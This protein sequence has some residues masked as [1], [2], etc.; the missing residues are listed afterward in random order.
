M[1]PGNWKV[2]VR[3]EPWNPLGITLYMVSTDPNGRRSFVTNFTMQ[4]ITDEVH[5][6]V[7]RIEG[8]ADEVFSLLQAFMDAAWDAGVRPKSY[9][10]PQNELAA[11]RAHLEDMRCIV[12]KKVDV[13]MMF[14]VNQK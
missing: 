14:N 10:E 5:E 2:I 8:H 13:P 4:T 11:V 1:L 9:D 6:K 7:P 3:H 12:A